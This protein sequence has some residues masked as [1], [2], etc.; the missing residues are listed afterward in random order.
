ML[1]RRTAPAAPLSATYE[2]SLAVVAQGRKQAN[3][4]GTTFIFDQSRY[5]LTS[6]DLPVTCNVIEASE[7][8][9][10]LCFVLKLEMSVVRELLGR[11]EIPAPD[12][13]RTVLRWLLVK[14]RRSCSMRVAGSWIY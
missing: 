5:L 7:D 6:L 10:Y 14:P 1:A 3:L 12:V 4:G 8:V 11:E 13:L 2:A 9:P